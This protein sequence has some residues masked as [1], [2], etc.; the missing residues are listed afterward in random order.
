MKNT[1]YYLLAL[2]LITSCSSPKYAYNFDHYDYNSGKKVARVATAEN[3]AAPV[4]A[5]KLLASA[6]NSFLVAETPAAATVNTTEVRKTYVQMTKS[7]RKEFRNDVKKFLKEKKENIKAAKKTNAMDNDLKL[8]SIF[9]AV[10]IVALI[11]GGDVFWIIGG[12]ALLVGVVFFIKWL[13]RQ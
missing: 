13:V 4:Q 12:I 1:L 6:D 3:E 7:E 11:I 2:V 10:G 9:G 5:E 8:A